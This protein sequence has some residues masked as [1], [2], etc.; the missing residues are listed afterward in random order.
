MR[1]PDLKRQCIKE[2]SLDE[3]EHYVLDAGEAKYRAEQIFRQIYEQRKETFA[4]LSIIPA[5]LRQKLNGDFSF[6]SIKSYETQQSVDGTI[7]FLFDLENGNS[8]E[9]VLIPLFD[10]NED[11]LKRL[12]LCVSSQVG[13]ALD[14]AFCATGKLK[15]TRNL[16]AAEI[17]EQILFVE[18]H[19]STKITNVVFMGMGEPL[20]NFEN[21]VKAV[22]I[23][24]HPKSAVI[25]RKRITISTSGIVPKI[26]L[27]AELKR[28]IK[29]AISLHATT[30]K[31]RNQ[32]MPVN[33][34]WNISELRESIEYYYRLT[35]IPITYEYILFEGMNDSME[36]VKRLARYVRSVPSKVNIIPFHDISFTLPQGFAANLVPADIGRIEKF[37]GQLRNEGVNAFVRTS[38]GF[39]IDA[40]CGQLAFSKRN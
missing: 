31:L 35:K 19:I 20:H 21:V 18:K 25:S 2:L 6:S 38:S 16:S 13:C 10:E 40:A 33:N 32:L 9:S 30:D 17:V 5:S 8:V 3:I 28:S 24:T 14:C 37:V 15:F 11:D 26:R 7:K 22:E 1:S 36:D 23:L 12:T 34:K 39:D 29:L 4:D 27:L